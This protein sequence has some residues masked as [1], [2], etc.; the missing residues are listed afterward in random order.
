MFQLPEQEMLRVVSVICE[1]LSDLSFDPSDL[2]VKFT[3]RNYENILS[4]SQTLVTMLQ[5]DKIHPKSAFEA[6]GL[7]VDTEEAYL[8]GMQWFEEQ[9]KR[10][11][12]KAKQ[13][14]E[15]L[16][17]QNRSKVVSVE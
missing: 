13:E 2:E 6:S 8:L 11:E 10:H 5:N 16:E 4:K 3:R 14:A 7:F 1:G 9:M 12:E 15:R 17:E